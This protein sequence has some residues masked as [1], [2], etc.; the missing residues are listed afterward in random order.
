[1]CTVEG[2]CDMKTVKKTT[3][4]G[5]IHF[6]VELFLALDFTGFNL[7][8]VFGGSE[9]AVAPPSQCWVQ[10]SHKLYLPQQ[11]P[12]CLPQL[13]MLSSNMISIIFSG[14]V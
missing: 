10:M 2:V 8:Y 14:D 11:F 1:M 3:Q 9:R 5:H 12:K 7:M 13:L 4:T 6:I